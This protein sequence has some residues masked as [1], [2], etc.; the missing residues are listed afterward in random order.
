MGVVNG[1]GIGVF[2]VNPL[3]M[4][5]GMAS[6]LLGVV[7]VGLKTFLSGSTQIL[8]VVDDV[9]SGTLFGPLPMNFLVWAAISALIVLGL[10]S[11]G[12]GRMIY[13]VGDNPVACRLAGVRVWQ[14]LLAVYVISAVLAAIAGLLFSGTTGSVGPDQTN[15]YLLPSVAAAVIG[16]TSILGGSGGY[17]GTIIGALILT[18]LNRLLLSLDTSEA[19]RQ[20]LYGLIVLILAWVYV[21]LT[22][23]KG[24]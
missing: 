12:L 7:T 19:F 13:A 22:G 24:S 4:T 18:V 5:L 2:K 3:I 23:Q 11:S 14:V 8:S 16:G 10:S 21:R 6:V 1:V 9:G 20:V 17:S 15:S